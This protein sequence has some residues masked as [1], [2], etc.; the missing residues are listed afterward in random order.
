MPAN[1]F[2]E[3]ARRLPRE[4]FLVSTM[5]L[6][7]ARGF[8]RTFP[9]EVARP[10]RFFFQPGGLDLPLWRADLIRRAR[11][12]PPSIAVAAGLTPEGGFVLELKREL[13][14]PFVLFLGTKDLIHLRAGSRVEGEGS[15]LA[16]ELIAQTEAIIVTS[17]ASWL[18]AYKLDTHPHRIEIIP[19]GVDLEMFAPGER[20]AALARKLG[21]EE[22]PLILTVMG[23]E[24]LHDSETLLRA[25][26]TV[27]ASRRSA[28]LAFVGEPRPRIREMARELSL[29]DAVRFLALPEPAER[30]EL[31]RLADAFVS[32]CREDR[33]QGV[34]QE[35]ELAFVEAMA[36]GLPIFATKTPASEELLDDEES[37]VLVEPGAHAKLAK[38]ILDTLRSR[39]SGAELSQSARRKAETRFS[40]TASAA[41][42]HEFL[43]IVLQR[44]LRVDLKFPSEESLGEAASSPA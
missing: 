8:D 7:G 36:S 35:L 4:S 44:R 25:F 24:P 5:P 11:R 14:I 26:A 43:R 6:P 33:A 1:L 18:E 10:K 22:G 15:E 31:Y 40:S 21:L 42:F 13:E 9:C 39:A 38:G 17:R 34:V 12:K 29:Q 20:S 19:P 16:R 41:R 32:T 30:A 27:R 37:G 3:L 23:E 2:G 28:L